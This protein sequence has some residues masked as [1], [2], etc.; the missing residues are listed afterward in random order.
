MAQTRTPT[1]TP[2]RGYSA[3]KDQLLAR[4]GRIEGQIRGVEGMVSDERYCIDILTQISAAQAALDKVALGLLDDHAHHC[5]IGAQP[6]TER[7][8]KTDELMAAVGRLM[9]RG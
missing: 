9:R 1:T 6:A 7:E 4:L 8:A 3:T 2:T 5:V